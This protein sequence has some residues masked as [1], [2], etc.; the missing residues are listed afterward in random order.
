M[1]VKLIA[2]DLDGTLMAPDHITVTE[3]TKKALLAAHEKGV[4]I[5]IATGRTLHF[6][7]NV[8]AQLPFVDYVICSNGAAVYD[9]NTGEYIYKNLISPENTADTIDFLNKNPVFYNV[10]MNGRI[11][12]QKGADRFFINPDMPQVFI[13]AFN[14]FA[15]VC[16]DIETELAGG[17]AELI[18]IF[19]S[20]EAS[21]ASIL[22]HCAGKNYKLASA[23]PGVNSAT[24]IDADKGNAIRGMCARLGIS[25]DEVMAF[26]DAQNDCPMLEA[27]GL[28]FAVAN[29][30]DECKASAK[31]IAPSNGEDGVAQMIEKYVLNI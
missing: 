14:G 18:D 2:S 7:D 1:S 15:T 21:H 28:S 20:D 26:G 4:K 29:G 30:D 24:V 5:S 25:T 31:E 16:E 12:V 23:A 10:Y 8:T 13:D 9:R 27:A 22:E 19:A 11:Y 17:S 3:R 6:T